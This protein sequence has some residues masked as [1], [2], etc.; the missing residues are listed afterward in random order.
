MLLLSYWADPTYILQSQSSGQLYVGQT[1][2]LDTRLKIHNSGANKSTKGRGPWI[3]LH[4]QTFDSRIDSCGLERK[5]KSWK[6]KQMI[7]K[8]IKA[9]AR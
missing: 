4:Y 2:N 7:L 1:Q 3:V 5:L 8:W 9:Q 6:S